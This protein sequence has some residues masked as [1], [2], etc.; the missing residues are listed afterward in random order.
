MIFVVLLLVD[1]TIGMLAM[2]LQPPPGTT[3]G[4]R[5]IRPDTPPL[6]SSNACG[7]GDGAV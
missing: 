2:I 1:C 7:V 6:L 4:E 5:G 3:I